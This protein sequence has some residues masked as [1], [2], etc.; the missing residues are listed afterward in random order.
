MGWGSIAKKLDRALGG[1]S[2]EEEEAA[3]SEAKAEP[4]VEAAPK[5]EQPMPTV[6]EEPAK[7]N[8]SE[9]P[10][11]W[12]PS[13]TGSI[14]DAPAITRESVPVED[15]PV[16]VSK[17]RRARKPKQAPAPTEEVAAVAT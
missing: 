13:G 16:K 1:Y 14:Y 9:D 11:K 5:E 15:A 8:A 3:K 6:R 17:P 7:T 10:M 2:S 12:A 4:E